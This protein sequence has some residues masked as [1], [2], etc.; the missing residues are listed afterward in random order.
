MDIILQN[1]QD[2]LNLLRHHKDEIRYVPKEID[3]CD[4]EVIRQL[5]KAL[6]TWITS[7]ANPVAVN[8]IQDL[9]SGNLSPAAISAN[10]PKTEEK[11]CAGNFDLINWFVIS[12]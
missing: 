7:Q 6:E 9:F 2:I 8:Q 4:P 11:F 3:N 10:Q 12:K 5:A 1:R